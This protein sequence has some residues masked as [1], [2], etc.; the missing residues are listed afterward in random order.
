MAIR[1]HLDEN[2]SGAVAIA[3][4]RRGIS[5]TTSAD[6][7]LIGAEDYEQLRFALSD[8]R[9]VV[10]HDDDFA[11]IHSQGVAHAG[12]C[13]CHRDKHSIG[14]LVHLLILVHECFTEDEIRG[15]F[16]YL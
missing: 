9:I 12:I 13:Y 6:A 8:N 7:G 3:L 1:F 5:V 2:V 16:E 4:R 15:H 14:E 11:R 10:T